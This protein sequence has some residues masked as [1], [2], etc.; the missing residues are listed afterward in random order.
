MPWSFSG[1]NRIKGLKAKRPFIS[2]GSIRITK[3]KQL[4]AS[5]SMGLSMSGYCHTGKLILWGHNRDKV[6]W[7]TME[8]D[9][10]HSL[11]YTTI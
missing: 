4:M 8:T 2:G 11:R 7:L 9:V 10:I 5:G 6:E 1:M 3:G